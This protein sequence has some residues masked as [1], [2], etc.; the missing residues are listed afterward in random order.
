MPVDALPVAE[1]D[2]AEEFEEHR[3]R[4]FSV[5]YRMLG[6]AAEAE[7]VVQDTYLRWA[8]ADRPGIVIPAAWLTK[9][10]VN[11]SLNRLASARVQREAY[12][13][14]WLPEP[15]ATGGPAGAPLGP[16]ERA[17]QRESVSVALLT[18]MERLTPAERAVFVLREAFG[19]GHGE[20]A[21]VLDISEAA[22]RQAHRRARLRLAEDRRRFEPSDR[23][24]REVVDR[25]L[26]AAQGGD[27]DALHAV[28]AED[29]VT[30]S[31]GGGKVTAARIPI[32]G[33]DRVGLFLGRLV[34]MVT[35]EH[36][37]AAVDVNGVPAI[38][39]LLRGDIIAVFSPEVAD[40]RIAAMRIVVNPDKLGYFARQMA[41]RG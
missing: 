12:V 39:V 31:D 41:A 11:L 38:M 8:A 40:G 18:L 20:V 35:R 37:L 36:V 15:V 19:Y 17:E 28:L 7:D 27:I 33:R 34:G 3:G 14:P 5:C 13:G 32:A 24:W 6:S 10:A 21:D 29:V 30:Y 16:L 22:S 1:H 26:D 4:L 9:V 23:R 25:F 2:G